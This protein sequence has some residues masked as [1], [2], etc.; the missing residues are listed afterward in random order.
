M[1]AGASH[2]ASRLPNEPTLRDLEPKGARVICRRT[3]TKAEMRPEGEA[4]RELERPNFGGP[5]FGVPR[6][7]LLPDQS[8]L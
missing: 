1:L 4:V 8:R 3:E 7:S 6:M 5:V 2:S